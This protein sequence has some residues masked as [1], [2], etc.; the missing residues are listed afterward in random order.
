MMVLIAFGVIYVPLLLAIA[1][2]ALEHR[3]DDSCS[4]RR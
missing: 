2:L 1:T 4:P 3:I